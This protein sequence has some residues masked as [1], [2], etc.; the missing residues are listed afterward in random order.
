M[1]AKQL[2]KV[3]KQAL[4]LG[5]DDPQAR[6]NYVHVI[7]ANIDAGVIVYLYVSILLA[8]CLLN[9]TILAYRP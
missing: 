8:I 5:F 9:R 3:T 7:S 6:F 2:I 4:V 1:C